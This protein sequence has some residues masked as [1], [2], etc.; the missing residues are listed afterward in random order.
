ML[1]QKNKFK[2]SYY[3]KYYNE[4]EIDRCNNGPSLTVIINTSVLS[5]FGVTKH[6]NKTKG[7]FHHSNNNISFPIGTILVVEKLYDVLHFSPVFSNHKKEGLDINSLLK[8]LISYKLTDNFSIDIAHNWINRKD[9]LE[10]FNLKQFNQRALY[11]TFQTL[12]NNREEI[13]SDIQDILFRTYDF[14][15]ANVNMDWTSIVLH[16]DKS[17]LGK[18]GYS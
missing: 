2:S 14:P 6:A 9:V 3:G 15:H 11:I 8:A 17:P 4:T 18:Y 1:N 13:I 12:G 16:G 5:S 7:I 10:L